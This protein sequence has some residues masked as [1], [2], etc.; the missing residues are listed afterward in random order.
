MWNAEQSAAWWGFPMLFVG[1][2]FAVEVLFFDDKPSTI[3]ILNK[4]TN[5]S[6]DENIN[7][8]PFYFDDWIPQTWSGYFKE[9]LRIAEKSK[10]LNHGLTYYSNRQT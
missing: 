1:G 6:M 4:N 5:K 8:M 10:V 3:A 2:L 7:E 9:N